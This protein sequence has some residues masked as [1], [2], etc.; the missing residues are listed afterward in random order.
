MALA[1][2]MA[3]CVKTKYYYVNDASRDWFADTTN[4][5]FTMEDENGVKQSFRLDEA[6]SYMTETGASILFIIPTYKGEHEHISQGGANSYGFQRQF[7]PI[8]W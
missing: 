3:S 7:L 4:L 2:V 5:H 8:N 1:F 6:D